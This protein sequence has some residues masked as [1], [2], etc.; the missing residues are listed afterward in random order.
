MDVADYN[1]IIALAI[2]RNLKQGS[3]CHAKSHAA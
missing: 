1:F 3:G 2:L